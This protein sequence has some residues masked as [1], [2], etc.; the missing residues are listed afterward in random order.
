MT[1]GGVRRVLPLR[2]REKCVDSTECASTPVSTPAIKKPDSRSNFMKTRQ[3]RF[4][5][6]AEREERARSIS[7]SALWRG[8][9]DA[10]RDTLARR[11]AGAWVALYLQKLR[12][13]NEVL[14]QLLDGQSYVRGN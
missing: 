9:F 11:R 2:A 10:P 1:R 14:A 6:T 8:G 4:E 5:P 3:T 13:A 7:L 12:D